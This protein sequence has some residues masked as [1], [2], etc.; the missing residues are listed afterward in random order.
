MIDDEIKT[1]YQK[2]LLSKLRAIPILQAAMNIPANNLKDLDILLED[3]ELHLI[4]IKKM[5]KE[6]ILWTAKQEADD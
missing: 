5:K 1:P 2:D 3:I 4:D 6:A